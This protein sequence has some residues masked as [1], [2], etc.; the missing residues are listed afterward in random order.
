MTRSRRTWALSLFCLA[1]SIGSDPLHRY[2]PSDMAARG[3]VA[4]GQ[5][6]DQPATVA[7]RNR[8]DALLCH[9]PCRKPHRVH[10]AQVGRLRVMTSATQGLALPGCCTAGIAFSN[11]R[12]CGRLVGGTPGRARSVPASS[13]VHGPGAADPGCG[14][15]RSMRWR[16]N[17]ACQI[18]WIPDG[19]R[20]R[21]VH[22]AVF[23]LNAT[24]ND[25]RHR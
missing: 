14:G 24:K 6:A 4:V 15:G 8:A 5:H 19:Q 20:S 23:M 1:N 21:M 16:K 12:G 25:R 17:L 18:G 7:D 13:P 9:H 3:D 10:S 2:R 11:L 22:D